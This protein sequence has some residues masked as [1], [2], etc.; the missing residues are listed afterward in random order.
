MAWGLTYIHKQGGGGRREWGGGREKVWVGM[1]VP[2]WACVYKPMQ[3]LRAP[4]STNCAN[5]TPHTR[6]HSVLSIFNCFLSLTSS[7]PLITYCMAGNFG[8]EFIKQIGGFESNP[9]IFHPPKLYSVLSSLFVII[10]ST[11]TIGLLRIHSHRH[12]IYQS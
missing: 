3:S 4:S 2:V 10:A 1:Q 6:P 12:F 7:Q 9:P 5:H 8:R 11:C